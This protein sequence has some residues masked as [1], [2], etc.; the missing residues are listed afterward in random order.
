MFQKIWEAYCGCSRNGNLE[1]ESI[2]RELQITFRRNLPLVH[3]SFL[4]LS[5]SLL[6]FPYTASFFPV[7]LPPPLLSCYQTP[8]GF[9]VSVPLLLSSCHTHTGSR[10]LILNSGQQHPL[11]LSLPTLQPASFSPMMAARYLL[12]VA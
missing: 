9:V 12:A 5:L 2:R 1:T 7:L 3:D 10:L 8:P 6:L 4:F 11:S